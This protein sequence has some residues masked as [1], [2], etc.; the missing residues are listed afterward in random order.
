MDEPGIND[1]EPA[2]E[3]RPDGTAGILSEL[4]HELGQPLQA[5]SNY[6]EA[7]LRVMRSDSESRRDASIHWIAQI[8]SQAD[9]AAAILRRINRLVR[10]TPPTDQ[11]QQDE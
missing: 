6:A 2:C 11:E 10:K 9:R 5:I 8:G 3:D 4:A 1:S 7:C